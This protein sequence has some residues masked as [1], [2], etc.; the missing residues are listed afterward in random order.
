MTDSED[1]HAL[2]TN[3]ILSAPLPN[4]W[5]QNKT[6]EVDFS[7]STDLS[8]LE[9][10]SHYCSSPIKRKNNTHT[11]THTLSLSLSISFSP[12]LCFDKTGCHGNG[13]R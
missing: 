9:P 2:T 5:Q 4:S 1:T 13:H 8:S 6:V 11:H 3:W 12:G 10:Y 7:S